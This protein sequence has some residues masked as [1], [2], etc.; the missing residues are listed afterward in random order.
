M[1]KPD[2]YKQ[3]LYK[4]IQE[5]LEHWGWRS[6]GSE[7]DLQNGE[8]FPWPGGGAYWFS[9]E[10][11]APGLCLGQGSSMGGA[12]QKKKKQLYFGFS[13]D[14]R[15]KTEILESQDFRKKEG[16]KN[17]GTLMVSPQN[18]AELGSCNAWYRKLGWENHCFSVF[19]LAS[20]PTQQRWES[21]HQNPR[22]KIHNRNQPTGNSCIRLT[23]KDFDS[24]IQK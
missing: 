8:L 24:N 1:E 19:C 4:A 14:W 22:K 5:L 7:G 9:V 13:Q 10:G 18:F 23:D 12:G 6:Q 17:W 20:L 21:Q 2:K 15:D 16:R 3:H 11:W